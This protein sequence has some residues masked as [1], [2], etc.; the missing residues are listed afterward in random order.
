VLTDPLRRRRHADHG[1]QATTMMNANAARP[2]TIE[3]R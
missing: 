2:P 1:Q 3:S